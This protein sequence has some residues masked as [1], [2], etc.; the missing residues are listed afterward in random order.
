MALGEAAKGPGQI[1]LSHRQ[2]AQFVERHGEVALPLGIGGVAGGQAFGDDLRFVEV[3]PGPGQIATRH[4][5]AAQS[6]KQEQDVPFPFR[7]AAVGIS[8]LLRGF[9][10]LG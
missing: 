10:G 3:A 4:R 6:D 7:I 8:E 5:Q 9:K 2:V 1:V